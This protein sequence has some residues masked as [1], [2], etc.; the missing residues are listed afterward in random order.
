MMNPRPLSMRKKVRLLIG[1]TIL[2]WAT[3]TMMHQLGFGREI[4]AGEVAAPPVEAPAEP[5]ADAPPAAGEETFV[6]REEKFVPGT[7]RFAAGATLEIRTEARVAGAEVRL[8]QVCRWTDADA[9]AFA[10]VADLVLTRLDEKRPFDSVTLQQIRGAL[11]DAGANLAMIRF[12]GPVACT[13]SRGDVELD[14]QKAL[15]QWVQARTGEAQPAE[16]SAA[17]A[18]TERGGKDGLDAVL[19][20][21][22]RSE[23]ETDPAKSGAARGPAAAVGGVRTLREVLAADLAE[24]LGLPAE[25]L[26][27]SFN[28]RDEKL[29]RLAEPAFRFHVE[30]KRVR[31]LGSVSWDVMLVAGESS[32]TVPIHAGARAWQRQVVLTRPLTFKQ[33][34]RDA[35]VSERR[36]LVD[37]L[38]EDELLAVGQVVG[39]QAA[40]DLK[41]GT[42]LTA[43][44]VDAVPLVQTGQFVTV[45]LARGG[46]KVKTVARAMEGG[47]FGQTVRLKNEATKDI[48]EA[49][50]T[51]PQEAT[52][53]PAAG[54]GDVASVG[55]D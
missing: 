21:G 25:Q 40:R 22:R 54:E 45:T 37:R 43:K 8:R 36:T 9:Q 16:E 32:Q 14:E 5:A 7:A 24:R 1:I 39:Q 30:P 42:V 50:L 52:L 12:A 38:P 20:E 53:D 19:A 15:E 47:S 18:K 29:L 33:V 34:I 17:A 28:P 27:L 10:P 49:V 3:Q 46:V 4:A 6:P 51:G 31:N 2:A 44:L 35:D 55:N 48:Y 11:H 26:E 13:V 23:S 41:P